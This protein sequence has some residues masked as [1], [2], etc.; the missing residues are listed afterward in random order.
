[1]WKAIALEGGGVLAEA[2]IGVLS[3]IEKR[4]SLHTFNAFSGSSAGALIASCL[5]SRCSIDK[6]KL[7][8]DARPDNL[9][10]AGLC[11][12]YGLCCLYGIFKGNRL[13]KWIEDCVIAM[14]GSKTI[15]F[16]QHR[17]RYNTY[18]LVT[19]TELLVPYSRTIYIDY[20]TDPDTTLV[21]ALDRSCSLPLIYQVK[22]EEGRMFVDGGLIDNLPMKPLLKLGL[23]PEE[24]I[25][26]RLLKSN[27][28]LAYEDWR[29]E[30]HLAGAP[31]LK[32]GRPPK[33]IAEVVTTIISTLRDQV[34]RNNLSGWPAVQSIWVD[35]GVI[36][37][38]DFDLSKEEKQFLYDAGVKAAEQWLLE[39]SDIKLTVIDEAKPEKTKSE[40]SKIKTDQLEAI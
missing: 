2:H 37:S 14:T 5:A 20:T 11:D 28:I 13:R 10:D 19:V 23:K 22:K 31:Q 9:L 25:G 32:M 16:K 15:T 1:M 12:W 8:A 36:S 35:V 7:I 26:I 39:R 30:Q 18:L 27:E 3:S 21:D 17:E 29:K 33:N 38:T 6:I 40:E 4:Q 24:I 34:M